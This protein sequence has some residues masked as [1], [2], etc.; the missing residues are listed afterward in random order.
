MVVQAYKEQTA[1]RHETWR[2]IFNEVD[3]DKNGVL[4]VDEFMTAMGKIKDMDL[5]ENRMRS[6]FVEAMN[7][8]GREFIDIEQFVSVR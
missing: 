2:D 4:D 3:D 8:T 5:T 1:A 7:D 6:L